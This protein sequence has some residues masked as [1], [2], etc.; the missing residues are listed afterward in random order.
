MPIARKGAHLWIN[1]QILMIRVQ[2]SGWSFAGVQKFAGGWTRCSIGV[3]V[4]LM[5]F[6]LWWR[7]RRTS[8]LHILSSWASYPIWQK[9]YRD[10]ISRRSS[11]APRHRARSYHQ[12]KHHRLGRSWFIESRN[13]FH[14]YDIWTILESRRGSP[15]HGREHAKNE[16]I[17]QGLWS[18]NQGPC[19]SPDTRRG[20]HKWCSLKFFQFICFIM[21]LF[22]CLIN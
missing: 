8:S 2:E 16:C 17:A 5:Y 19:G 14:L 1:H 18:R 15:K 21:H 7:K 4:P 10:S 3:P 12:R 20:R 22:Y 6:R 13:I 11:L 9:I